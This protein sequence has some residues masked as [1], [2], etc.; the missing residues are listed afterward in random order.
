MWK[1]DLADFS[2]IS[3]FA[4]KFEREGGGRLDI[5]VENAGV[6]KSAQERTKDDWEAM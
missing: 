6:G 5:L 3:A 4:D 1:V 2:S